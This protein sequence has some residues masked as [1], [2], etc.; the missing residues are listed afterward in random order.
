VE[1][2][3]R[4]VVT[5]GIHELIGE[6]LG[7]QVGGSGAGIEVAVDSLGHPW[8]LSVTGG[9]WQWTGSAWTVVPTPGAGTDFAIGADGTIAY[10]TGGDIHMRSGGVWSNTGGQGIS[11]AV[12]SDGTIWTATETGS[13]WEYSASTWTPK[14]S[15][16]GATSVAAAAAG[17]TVAGVFNGIVH[18]FDGTTWTSQGAAADDIAMDALGAWAVD[19]YGTVSVLSGGVWYVISTGRSTGGAFDIGAG[20]GK[21]YVLSY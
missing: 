14:A 3:Y 4:G 18:T 6:R 19:S 21:Q 13:V 17:G 2:S 9:L 5:L 12:E 7:P 16:V 8:A 15:W 1:N 20:G 11:V 10:I